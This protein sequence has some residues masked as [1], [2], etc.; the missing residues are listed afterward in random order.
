[1]SDGKP[2]SENLREGRAGRRVLLLATVLVV[3][4]GPDYMDAGIP[5]RDMIRPLREPA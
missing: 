2:E 4:T 5:H 1:M 3:A